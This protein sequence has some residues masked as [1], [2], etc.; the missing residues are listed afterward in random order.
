M[1]C[2]VVLLVATAGC[3]ASEG[4]GTRIVPVKGKVTFKGQP[5]TKGVIKFRPVD[6]G[7]EASGTIQRDGTFVLSTF[8]EGDGA[9]LGLNQVSIRFTGAKEIIPKKY[10]A[11]LTSKLEAEVTLEKTEFTFELN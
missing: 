1:K 9:A 10:L 8:K 7:R 3:G 6:Q 5:L 2:V 4:P 11:F